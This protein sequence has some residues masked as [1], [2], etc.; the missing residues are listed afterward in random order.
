[1]DIVL[2]MNNFSRPIPV[3]MPMSVVKHSTVDMCSKWYLFWWNETL[4][5]FSSDGN[6]HER[7]PLYNSDVSDGS[8][9]D[10]RRHGL[11]LWTAVALLLQILKRSDDREWRQFN[12]LTC[13]I[14]SLKSHGARLEIPVLKIQGKKAISDPVFIHPA[15]YQQQRKSINKSLFIKMIC[16]YIIARC[17]CVTVLARLIALL[18]TKTLGD[19]V[20]SES[21]P[22]VI[23]CVRDAVTGSS[24]LT[25]DI[26]E[27]SVSEFTTYA[28]GQGR[29]Y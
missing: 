8:S 22:L 3:P 2:F 21:V 14:L 25:V 5:S 4:R 20:T 9:I 28:L 6:R 18:L 11:D 29:V 1:M 26:V 24:G 10:W 17:P 16:A 7:K 19:I 12:E 23:D 15:L 27:F 13:I